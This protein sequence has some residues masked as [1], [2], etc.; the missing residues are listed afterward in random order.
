[1]LVQDLEA[2]GL[3]L[4]DV[5]VPAALM[6][7]PGDLDPPRLRVKLAPFEESDLAHPEGQVV[8]DAQHR[9]PGDDAH[10]LA[11]G[12]PLR[13]RDLVV[14][15]RGPPFE[16]R[17]PHD[18]EEPAQRM[19]KPPDASGGVSL[20]FEALVPVCDVGGGDLI[21]GF[22]HEME[23][24]AYVPAVIVSGTGRSVEVEV[25]PEPLSLRMKTAFY[26]IHLQ[27]HL[28]DGLQ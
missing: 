15:D 17:H 5:G 9:D 18:V 24:L 11:P 4:K 23:K 19:A 14:H 27:G 26:L 28:P 22:V 3:Q 12:H 25:F 21:Q 16:L 10:D 8:G 2:P 1:M 6:F 7:Q 13:I 20:L